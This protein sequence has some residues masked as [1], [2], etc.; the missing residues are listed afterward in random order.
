MSTWTGAAGS[1]Y[2]RTMWEDGR[3]R[4]PW[5]LVPS[6]LPLTLSA[7]WA[8]ALGVLLSLV[9]PGLAWCTGALAWSAANG[10]R[11]VLE[12]CPAA[13]LGTLPVLGYT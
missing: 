10:A 12:L 4:A 13:L 5:T 1:A 6:P 9:W 8:L 11:S 7:G 3:R 2:M